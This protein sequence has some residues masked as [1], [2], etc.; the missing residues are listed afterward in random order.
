MLV[1]TGHV[2]PVDG[3]VITET[4]V[5]DVKNEAGDYLSS[6]VVGLSAQDVRDHLFDNPGLVT[7]LPGNTA[8]LD[9][10]GPQRERLNGGKATWVAVTA[11]DRV[12]EDG[13][14]FER[15]LAE[16]YRCPAGKPADVEATH[17]TL[18]EGAVF[19]PG[20]TPESGDV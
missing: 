4:R 15:F 11:E 9:V 14:D 12:P 16:F 2:D 18:H 6:Y 20:Q 19:A 13:A 7:H 1:E 3:P 5:S 10:V 8:V 17:W